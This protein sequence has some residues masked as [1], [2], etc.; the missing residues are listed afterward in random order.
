[1]ATLSMRVD[2]TS[3]VAVAAATFS[4]SRR[5]Y[6]RDEVRRL[7]DAV[8]AELARLQDEVDGLRAA[9]DTARPELDE[10][11]VVGL[12]GEEA[13]RVLTTARDAAARTRARAEEEAATLLDQARANATHQREEADRE[14]SR[15]R[16]DASAT[17]AAEIES[18]KQEGRRMVTEARAVRQRMLAD[19]ARRRDAAV[20]RLTDLKADRDRLLVVFEQARA[21]LEGITA[22]LRGAAP[23]SE[24]VESVEEAVAAVASASEIETVVEPEP[25]AVEPVEATEPVAAV[26]PVEALDPDAAFLAARASALEPVT[27]SL[28][29]QLKRALADEQ[30]EVLDGLR[31]SNVVADPDTVFGPL[32]EYAQRYRAAAE[33]DLLAAA[34]AGAT[35]MTGADPADVRAALGHQDVLE[36]AG[37]ELT[38]QLVEPLRRR[39]GQCVDDADGDALEAGAS[40]RAAY[41]EW[42]TQ[43][44]DALAAHLALF[45]HGRATTAAAAPGTPVHWVVDPDEPACPDCDD[46]ALAGT[47]M[48]GEAF[49]TGHQQAPAH[50]GCRCGIAPTHD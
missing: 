21:A 18:A 25:E 37:D 33:D 19:L 46:N 47:V 4:S 24:I 16:E 38:A 40:V 36:R 6:D 3:P 26:D 14:V 42:K 5:G 1:M 32:P 29:R 34:V 2:P 41:R 35:A 48:L 27:A 20:T 10:A 50:I 11:T 9:A 44:V 12:L 30:N 17:A 23:E 8:A 45:A 13:A 31:R 15:Q 43:R 7:L 49:P 39:L 28:S 22:S